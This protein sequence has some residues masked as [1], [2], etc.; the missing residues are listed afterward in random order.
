MMTTPLTPEGNVNW[1][2]IVRINWYPLDGYSVRLI[3]KP[4]EM[5]RI[6]YRFAN[7]M[8]FVTVSSDYKSPSRVSVFGINVILRRPTGPRVIFL[9]GPSSLFESFKRY[10]TMTL[11][12]P[13]GVDAPDFEIT[14]MLPPV[15]W[16]TSE[17]MTRKI[18]AI[19]KGDANYSSK[20]AAIIA[21]LE[22]HPT[23]IWPVKF[24][25]TAFIGTTKLTEDEKAMIA[26][27]AVSLLDLASP[28]SPD[29]IA[30][31]TKSLTETSRVICPDC[32]GSRRITLFTTT[33]DCKR[34][35]KDGFLTT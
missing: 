19:P 25:V 33:V 20:T 22:P 8:R 10:A 1:S 17:Q 3:G 30:R 15:S 34:C 24:G 11:N 12:D 26:Q 35:D 27:D 2:Q 7:E 18:A 13:G 28:D 32:K 4:V 21:E 23:S 5:H 9:D 14:A 29:I 6:Y 31:A 16:I